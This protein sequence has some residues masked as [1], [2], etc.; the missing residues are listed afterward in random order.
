MLAKNEQK[1]LMNKPAHGKYNAKK[2]ETKRNP[3]KSP[4]SIRE[5]D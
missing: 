1:K 3:A 4:G 2:E 5:D